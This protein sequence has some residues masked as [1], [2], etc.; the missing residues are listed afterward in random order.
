MNS[1]NKTYREDLQLLRGISVVIVVLYHLNIFGFQNGYLGVDIFFVLSGFFM[2]Q[3]VSKSSPVEF[4]KRR[5]KRLLPAYFVT[6]FFTTLIVSIFA[7]S[8]D[9]NQRYDRLLFDIFGLSNFAFWLENTYFD[10]SSFKPLLNLWSLGVELQFY[11]IA[12]FLLPFLKNR[13][14]TFI[15]LIFLS[16]VLSL[17]II[18]ISPK[19]SFF[20]L[21][22]RLWE[23][24][25]GAFAAWFLLSE[26]ESYLK[27][28]FRIVSIA[29][30]ICVVLFYPLSGDSLD[31][32]T[33]HPSIAALIVAISTTVLL[34]LR[35]DKI[36]SLHSIPSRALIK[37]GNYSYS[38]YLTHFPVIVL[39]NYS[40]FD[41]TKLGFNTASDL[42]WIIFLTT[43]TSFL[44]FNY[45]E[46][47]RYSKRIFLPISGIAISCILL[48]YLGPIITDLK[49]SK[50]ELLIFNAW[51][52]RSAYRCGM[53]NRILNPFASIC[54]IGS[55]DTDKRILLLGN[56]HA[57]SIKTSFSE[58]IAKEGYSTYFYSSNTPLMSEDTNQ[59]IVK[60][61]V[62]KSEIDAIVVHYNYNFFNNLDFTLMLKRFVDLMRD[63]EINVYFI[64]PIPKY[65]VNIPEAMLRSLNEKGFEFPVIN[66][67][68]YLLS[69]PAFLDF[70]E[71]NKIDPEFVEFPHL[72]M[73]KSKNCEYSNNGVPYYFDSHH[74]TLTGAR[75]LNPLYKNLV[76]NK[77]AFN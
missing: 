37:L 50:K 28:F 18:S 72:Y 4:Y 5:F 58:E 13:K 32:L 36:I 29:S 77:I 57:D 15:T 24:L 61:A 67:Q 60:N 8:L 34:I 25:L 76:K 26:K 19:T 12:P 51:E 39:V 42:L 14:K 11:L 21:P 46:K 1:L 63:E 66:K 17:L 40:P 30:L 47:L 49:Y 20:M 53:A 43:I 7:N 75:V 35:L 56:S 38:I 52:D 55:M 59:Y 33:G 74:L 23:F 68:E 22:T 41:G 6:I 2:A 71:V 27:Q 64:A 3:L 44:M 31:I 54:R 10:S 69:I 16:W 45:V 73:C 65:E 9:A 70:I 62:L 48:I